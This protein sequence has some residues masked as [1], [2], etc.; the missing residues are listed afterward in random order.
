[1]ALLAHPA[2][3]LL[4]WPTLSCVVL[5]YAYARNRPH[6]VLGKSSDGRISWFWT[7]L[8]LPWLLFTWTTWIVLA[9]FSRESRVSRLEGTN[10]HLGRWPLLGPDLSRFDVVVDL[11]A[12]LPRW[13]RFAHRY[14]ALPNL[15]G[16]PLVHDTPRVEIGPDTVVLVHCAQGHGRTASFVALLLCRRGI[17]STVEEAIALIHDG[18]PLARMSRSQRRAVVAKLNVQPPADDAGREEEKGA[19]E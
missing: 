8:N 9:V 5:A 3:H 11:A 15:D 7:S 14:E 17:T 12:E 1:M 18:R 19:R 2:R 6:L 4:L 16:M 10:I 13:Y